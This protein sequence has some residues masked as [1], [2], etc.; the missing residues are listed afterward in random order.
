MLLLGHGGQG[1]GAVRL[2]GRHSGGP[3]GRPPARGRLRPRRRGLPGL[4]EADEGND[5]CDRPLAQDDRDGHAR[6]REHVD[7]GRAVLEAI[8]LEDA[9]LGDRRFDKVFAFNVA[10]FWQQPEAAL[11]AVRTSP[12]MGPSTSSGT[13]AT[14]RRSEPGTSGTS[15]PTGYARADSPSNKVL[16]EDLRPVPA[17]CRSGGPRADEQGPQHRVAFSHGR[18]TRGCE[19]RSAAPGIH[20]RAKPG[21]ARQS[22]ATAWLR[23]RTNR[24]GQSAQLCTTETRGSRFPS[25]RRSRWGLGASALG[26]TRLTRGRQRLHQPKED[27]CPHPEQLLSLQL[28]AF[29]ARRRRCRATSR[30]AR[31]ATRGWRY[32][33]DPP[34]VEE[35]IA[36]MRAAGERVHGDRVRGLINAN[37]GTPTS[38]RP[39]ST[40]K[41]STTP[42]SSTPS[43]EGEH[44]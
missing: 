9:D 20:A 23:E 15:W 34:R 33:A 36:V 13:R 4:R 27:A 43:T 5:H 32:P 2:G 41:A 12:G 29:A 35:I 38:A 37:W 44:Q 28:R 17:V 21:C 22:V 25:A 8:A 42:R 30:G 10:R 14:P 1:I 11:G 40:F 24:E 7:A 16:V 39:R 19:S 31:R 18:N 3:P 26:L 6:N